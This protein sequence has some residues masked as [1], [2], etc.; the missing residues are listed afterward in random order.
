LTAYIVQK[1]DDDD[2]DLDSNGGSAVEL[3]WLVL[4]I[5]PLSKLPSVELDSLTLT[6]LLLSSVTAVIVAALFVL[7]VLFVLLRRSNDIR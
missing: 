2:D 3:I 1:G 5:R 7:F 6:P 4:V